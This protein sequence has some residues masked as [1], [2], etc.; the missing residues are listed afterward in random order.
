[1]NF[2]EIASKTSIT[3][4]RS[5]L[6]TTP[7]LDERDSDGRTALFRVARNGNHEKVK[8]LLHHGADPNLYDKN[9]VMPLQTASYRGH[10]ECVVELVSAG[11][12]LDWCQPVMKEYFYSETA[13]A[14]AARNSHIEIVKYLIG[15]GASANCPQQARHTGLG[16][17]ADTGHFEICELLINSGASINRKD[18]IGEYP[19]HN[20]VSR[21]H[22]EIVKLLIRYK[23]DVNVVNMHGYTPVALSV[24]NLRDDCIPILCEFIKAG[25]DLN[26]TQNEWELRP[27]DLALSANLDEVAK[28]LEISGA[29]P[30]KPLK[31]DD[32]PIEHIVRVKVDGQMVSVPFQIVIAK[33]RWEAVDE[34]AAKHL[35]NLSTPSLLK[36]FGWQSSP[37]HWFMIEGANRPASRARLIYYALGM[38][39]PPKGREYEDG[40]I[41]LGET[42]ED[43]L[44][45]FVSLGLLQQLDWQKQVQMTATVGQ[46]RSLAKMNGLKITSKKADLLNAL[47]GAIPDEHFEPILSKGPLYYR[48]TQ[49]SALLSNRQSALNAAE[50]RIRGMVFDALCAQDLSFAFALFL[51]LRTL[52][53]RHRDLMLTT[54]YRVRVTIGGE[55]PDSISYDQNEEHIFKAA[56]ALSE[57]DGDYNRWS[58]FGIQNPPYDSIEGRR[59]RPSEFSSS[60]LGLYE[61]TIG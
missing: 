35:K 28:I 36:N 53:G 47:L 48:T 2:A 8:L 1:M 34:V 59:L 29:K 27:M 19:L 21:N 14:S 60:I 12:N 37:R 51:D 55:V 39:N 20:A 45:R 4:L 15:A 38:C 30:G 50:N 57:L 3:N 26:L 56:A 16:L 41:T 23:A 54:L 17:A 22:L 32:S 24:L 46:L 5:M 6:L 7:N 42:Y 44:G 31:E 25:A 49:G 52:K 10:Y 33:P 18:H 58:L 61:S 9:G 13:L 11:A 40:C 43:A